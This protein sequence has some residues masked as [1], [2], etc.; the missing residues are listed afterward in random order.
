MAREIKFR[1]WDKTNKEIIPVNQL[2]WNDKR[3]TLLKTYELMQYTGLKDKEE[4]EIY[5]GDIVK[6]YGSRNYGKEKVLIREVRFDDCKFI[7]HIKFKSGSSG[8][9]YLCEDCILK[10]IGNIYENP[11]LINKLKE[12]E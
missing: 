7:G 6:D 10:V 1:A 8:A 12:N 2:H 4:T 11:E 9:S 3:L 5:E